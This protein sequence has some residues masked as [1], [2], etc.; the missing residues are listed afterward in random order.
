[1]MSCVKH[2]EVLHPYAITDEG[3]VVYPS[4]T[5]I[6]KRQMYLTNHFFN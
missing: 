1:M 3:I 6:G 2:D 4:E 5:V